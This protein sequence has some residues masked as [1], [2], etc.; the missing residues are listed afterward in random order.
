MKKTYKA[1]ATVTNGE[2][3]WE[4]VIYSGYKT[5]EEANE[6]INRFLNHGYTVT[7]T[8]IVEET[9]R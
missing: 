9:A 5:A 3:E 6:G 1:V 7:K 2:R 4:I 8:W